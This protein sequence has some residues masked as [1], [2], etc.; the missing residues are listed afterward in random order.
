MSAT[1]ILLLVEDDESDVLFLKRAFEKVGV[2]IHLEV[3][4]DGQKAVDYLAGNGPYA[5][6]SRY[7]APTHVLLDLKLPELSGLEVLEWIRSEPRLREL[8]VT[9]L[10]SSGQE[11]DIHRARELGVD[12]Y[13]VKPMKFVLLLDVAK[14]IDEWV[15]TGRAPE[16]LS[17][18]Q[19][20]PRSIP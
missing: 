12:A 1:A 5:D 3:V 6:R 10:T 15:R 17:P 18:T 2:T 7:P 19:A 11:S 8:R 4:E 14:A 16:S 9:I 13:L 20:I